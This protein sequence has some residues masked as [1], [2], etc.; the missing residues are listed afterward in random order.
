MRDPARI[1]SQARRNDANRVLVLVLTLI[2][3]LVVLAAIT[4]ELP[5]AAKG[6]GGALARLLGAI[7]LAWLFANTVYALHYAHLYYAPHPDDPGRDCEGL[8]FP[9]DQPPDYADFL[10]FAATMG[11]T[12]QTSDVQVTARHMRRVALGQGLAAFVFN[13]GIIGLVINALSGLAG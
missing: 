7:V 13:L 9:G 6:D 8:A 11:M 5:R 10:Y 1:R 4:G 12:F 2:I 3:V